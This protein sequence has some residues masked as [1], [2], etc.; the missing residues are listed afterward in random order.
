MTGI[1]RFAIAENQAVPTDDGKTRSLVRVRYL[2]TGL[3]CPPCTAT[4]ERSLKGAK[5]IRSVKVDW[6]TKNAV[7]EFDEKQ[8]SAQKVAGLI[9]ATPHMMGGN[10]RYGGW[11]SLKVDGVSDEKTAARA[12]EALG[13]VAG[14]S[15]V[16]VYPKQGSVGIAFDAKG[17]V[18]LAD[19][20]AALDAVGL[21]GA[22]ESEPATKASAGQAQFDPHAGM[23]MGANGVHMGTDGRMACPGPGCKAGMAMPGGTGSTTVAAPTK[24]ARPASFA[25]PQG[26]GC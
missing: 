9:A 21:K 16:A 26:C 12:K 23:A 2:I 15:Q 20:L 3:H 14:V 24:A 6:N 1:A 18:A 5:G 25:R 11:L 22:T 10:M 13:G 19:L 7:I 4:V 8:V 17:D